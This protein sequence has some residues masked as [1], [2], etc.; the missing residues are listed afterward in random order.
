M[1]TIKLGY[2]VG[3][4]T[5]IHIPIGHMAVVGQTQ[6]AGKTTTLEALTHRMPQDYRA[7]AFVTKR[8]EGSFADVGNR[9]VP[10]FKHEANWQFVQSIL[11]A[12][13]RERMK[14]ERSW[15][16][17]ASKGAQSLTDV[18]RN[19]RTLLKSAKGLSESVYYTL[20]NYL[21]IVVPQIERLSL[22]SFRPPL[23]VTGV[24][25]VMD[26]SGLSSEMQALVI[27]STLEHVYTLERR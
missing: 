10:Y 11:E 2:E 1:N 20:D 12:T 15:I 17:R 19:V 5:E 9:L 23:F 7:V 18:Q 22:N 8:G 6:A 4:G 25:N 27:R 21:D 24:P 13:M 3:T 16:M 14:F 26:L